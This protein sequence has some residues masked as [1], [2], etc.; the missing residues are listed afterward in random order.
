VVRTDGANYF[1]TFTVSPWINVQSSGIGLINDGSADQSSRL[2]T[3]LASPPPA[4][5]TL[6]FP[7]VN[8]LNYVFANPIKFAAGLNYVFAGGN[9]TSATS[10]RLQYTGSGNYGFGF[11]DAPNTTLY[12]AVFYCSNGGSPPKT[13]VAMGQ[14]PSGGTAV[15]QTTCYSCAINGYASVALWYSIGA[16]E[17]YWPDMKVNYNGGG[18]ACGLYTNY[19]D[20][21]TIGPSP[22]FLARSNTRLTFDNMHWVN[23]QSSALAH[24]FC[25]YN[26][27]GSGNTGDIT[28]KD[29]YIAGWTTLNT[30]TAGVYF[31]ESGI[32]GVTIE[33]LRDENHAY[34]ADVASGVNLYDISII[35]NRLA[36]SSASGFIHAGGAGTF[37][38]FFANTNDFVTSS[39]QSSV[40]DAL[41]GLV[42]NSHVTE[43]FVV[44]VGSIDNSSSWQGYN[45]P[46]NIPALIYS[47]GTP[48]TLNG[49]SCGGTTY[50]IAVPNGGLIHAGGA[51]T[52]T[53]TMTLGVTVPT[54]AVCYAFN[55]STPANLVTQNQTLGNTVRFTGVS[56][57]TDTIF[58]A[59]PFIF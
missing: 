26:N 2:N 48:A 33:N 10:C 49:A 3:Y 8:G 24:M 32:G 58:W 11:V 56:A 13:C 18:A 47:G 25:L 36:N 54:G 20:A 55:A 53:F 45:A 29:G 9:S 28:L 12:S 41:P 50:N 31:A 23:Q 16:E 51:G 14:S 30:D 42:K 27:G 17:Q 52:C 19:N 59:C 43:P 44:T 46:V 4:G 6:F 40:G 22:G 38:N 7:C 37:T 34:L 21:Q 35:H 57:G 5:T 15:I 1:A 39:L